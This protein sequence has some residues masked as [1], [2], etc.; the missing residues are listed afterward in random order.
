[1]A[2]RNETLSEI[3]CRHPTYGKDIYSIV[4]DGQ[5]WKQYMLGKEMAIHINHVPY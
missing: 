5:K 4:Y 3:V 1:V 2:Y